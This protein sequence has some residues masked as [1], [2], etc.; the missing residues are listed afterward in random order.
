MFSDCRSQPCC[1]WAIT[2]QS[3]PVATSSMTPECS[4]L[5]AST[6]MP[7]CGTCATATVAKPSK[8]TPKARPPVPEAHCMAVI[9]CDFGDHRRFSCTS[10]ECSL[11]LSVYSIHLVP[12]EINAAAFSPDGRWVLTAGEDGVA[13]VRG[14]ASFLIFFRVN[15]PV[16]FDALIVASLAKTLP[17]PL[18]PSLPP[19]S[20][21]SPRVPFYTSSSTTVC[22][23]R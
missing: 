21:T 7:R 14:P 15:S 11:L 23:T 17:T 1:P 18:P 3:A 6:A 12:A 10:L 13:Q 5:A 20:G 16:N 9:C 22:P 2:D 4:C 8:D 19:R